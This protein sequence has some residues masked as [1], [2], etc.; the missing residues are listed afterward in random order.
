MAG[1]HRENNRNTIGKCTLMGFYRI[2]LVDHPNQ[3][4]GGLGNTGMVSYSYGHVPV[5]TG[6]FYGWVVV[7]NVKIIP[8]LP[9]EGY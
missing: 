7:W 1:N 8:H 9:G 5:L 3:L 4:V 6:G 2:Y